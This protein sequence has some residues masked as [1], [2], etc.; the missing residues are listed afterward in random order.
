MKIAKRLFS[1]IAQNN[2]YTFR[3]RYFYLLF[4]RF[5]Y[6]SFFIL[7]L[8]IKSYSIEQIKTIHTTCS[9]YHIKVID[10]SETNKIQLKEAKISFLNAFIDSNED[11]NAQSIIS[12][13]EY[14]NY[15][16]LNLRHKIMLKHY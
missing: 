12:L 2:L 4:K 5:F 15:K 8:Y 14:K 1:Q 13:I 9:I 16:L 10:V 6:I 11:K 7:Y 3:Y